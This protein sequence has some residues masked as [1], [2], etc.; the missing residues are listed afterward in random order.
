MVM[1]KNIWG[2]CLSLGLSLVISFLLLVFG[3]QPYQVSG[4]SMTPTLQDNERVY[5]SKLSHTLSYLPDYGDIVVID[6]RVSRKRTFMD[7]IS[8]FPLFQLL[9]GSEDRS[10]YVKRVVGKP[11]DTIEFKEHKVYLNGTV[12][13]EPYIKEAMT[14]ESTTK[15]VVPDDNVFV[16]GDNRN[17]SSDS[18]ILGYIPLD[19][20]MGKKL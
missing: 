2:W 4:Q 3:V 6:S 8:A 11:G 17:N 1:L 13:D 10:I 15:W 14:Y 5:V 19:H 12:L 18:R 9:S 7:D 20:V 16:M